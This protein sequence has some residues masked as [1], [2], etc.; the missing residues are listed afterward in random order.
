MWIYCAVVVSC[1]FAGRKS[2]RIL[3][4]MHIGRKMTTVEDK[5]QRLEANF[6][7][8]GLDFGQQEEKKE[9][10]QRASKLKPTVRPS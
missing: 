2:P 5:L 4:Q 3:M 6:T 9:K 8:L 1:P 7:D 10:G